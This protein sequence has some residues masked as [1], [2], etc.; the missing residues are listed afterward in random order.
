MV[1]GVL[2]TTAGFRP[3]VVAIDAATGE[4]LWSYRLDEG[5]AR[6]SG[7][8]QRHPR[9]RVLDRRQTGAD[10]PGHARLSAGLARRKDR[11][12]RSGVRHATA[13]SI[14]IRTSISHRPATASSARHR[15]PS[16]SETSIVFGAA[17]V[18]GTA[19]RSKENTKGYIRGFDV[20]SGK[21]LWTFHT[22][23]QPGEFGN[24]T[25]L[26]DSWSYTGNTTV[27][28]PFSADEEL[29]YV[30]L[31]VETP[32]GDFY[33]GHRPG[34]NLFAG[35]LVCLD[36]RTGKRVWHQQ[37][38][39]H[40]IWDYDLASPPNLINI[41]VNGKPIRA[42]AQVTK[43]AL[44]VRVRSRERHAGVADRRS[45]S[46]SGHGAGR[47]VRADAAASD[48]ARALRSAGRVRSGSD[49]LHARA[50][51]RSARDAEGIQ[52]R[53][54]VHAADRRRRRRPARHAADS[55]GAGC[56]AV[57]GRG[58]GS[59]NEHAVRAVGDEHDG[60]ARSSRAAS[61]RT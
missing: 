3:N 22:I 45:E 8:A 47:M 55:R 32:T 1:G 2:Y 36:A 7:A 35:S 17:M 19:P 33:G 42:V 27:W 49:R 48:E 46:R 15:P 24:D 10:H 11:A 28:S 4:T 50:E 54:A 16:S 43:W 31:P 25:W 12:A 58:V 14:C 41:T 38:V 51:R 29:G 20:R 26:N 18:G 39:H 59:R 53:S 5:A 13:S 61:D 56:G 30:Y 60:R 37:L 23:P 52:D 21:R 40:D 44:P 57:A 6:R 34:N 9:R